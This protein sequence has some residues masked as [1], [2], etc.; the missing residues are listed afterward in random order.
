MGIDKYNVQYVSKYD[1]IGKWGK[2]IN[3]VGVLLK[4]ICAMNKNIYLLG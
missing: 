3:Y 1:H 2:L 4:V